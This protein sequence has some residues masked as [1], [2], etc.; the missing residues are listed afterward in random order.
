MI[1]NNHDDNDDDNDDN[2]T[3]QNILVSGA[4][5]VKVLAAVGHAPFVSVNTKHHR[6]ASAGKMAIILCFIFVVTVPGT[7]PLFVRRIVW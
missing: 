1:C 2:D 7:Y 4:G 3:Y 6:R 5:D